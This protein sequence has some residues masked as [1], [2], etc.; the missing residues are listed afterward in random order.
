MSNTGILLIHGFAGNVEEVKP[1]Y[2][3]LE[4]RGYIVECPLLPGHGQTKREL[5]LSAHSDWVAAVEQ[6]YLRLSKRCP[7]IIVI[8]FS[9][10]GLLAVNLWNY[11]F[12]AMITINTP[13]YYWN[14]NIIAA[15]LIMNFREYGKK[16]FEAA[17][18]KSF[19]SLLEFQK[20]LA[21]TKPMFGNI[22]CKT[23]VIQALDDDTVHY[24]S[25]DYILRKVRADKSICKL[26]HGGHMIFQSKNGQDVCRIIENFIRRC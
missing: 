20:L 21:K 9:M 5:S 4:Q 18:D 2:E 14:I 17:T 25:A 12:S 8:G 10:G 13:V 6:A 1:L 24:K 26:S 23:M 16:Y 3:Y 22:T 7:K 15:N 19:S 11:G